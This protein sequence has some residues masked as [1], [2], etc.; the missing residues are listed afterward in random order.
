[1]G[2]F[3]LPLDRGDHVEIGRW[4]GASTIDFDLFIFECTKKV[5]WEWEVVHCGRLLCGHV[6]SVVPINPTVLFPQVNV[7]D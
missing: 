6:E 5:N 4:R 3:E 1:M 7:R 2:K